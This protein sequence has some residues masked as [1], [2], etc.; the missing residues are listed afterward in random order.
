[1]TTTNDPNAFAGAA[2]KTGRCSS[3]SATEQIITG[4]KLKKHY[5]SLR[6]I[7]TVGTGSVCGN[8]LWQREVYDGGHSIAALSYDTDTTMVPRT[9]LLAKV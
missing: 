9:D 8:R 1:M 5:T 7:S 6:Q 3:N 2:T 4:I